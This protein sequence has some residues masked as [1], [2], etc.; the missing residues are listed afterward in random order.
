MNEQFYDHLLQ[1]KTGRDDNRLH[2][3]FLYHRY[4]PTPYSALDTL[5][6]EYELKSHDR[7]VD[8][9]CGKGRL[10]FYIHYK[11]GATVIGV[12]MD[13]TFYEEAIA[14]RK[15]YSKKMSKI[16]DN[17]HFICCLAEEY[18]VNP[19]DNRFYFFNPFTIQV[20]MQ[21][22][23]NILRSVEQDERE[24]EIILYYPSEDYIY[25]LEN[26]TAFQLKKE[27]K[28]PEL[29]PNNANERFLI[30]RL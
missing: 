22:V 21:V 9:G 11:F 8:F 25:Y 15:S 13:Q 30:Y 12:E 5:F 1:I 27:V 17:M 29:F 28:L 20:F 26:Y 14:N 10:N 7:V 24:L 18:V 6:S 16:H 19:A 23:N 3:S 4:E 2:K